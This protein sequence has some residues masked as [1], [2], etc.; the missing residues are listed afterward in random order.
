MLLLFVM[1]C[2]YV[3]LTSGFNQLL[4]LLVLAVEHV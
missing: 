1:I 4:G 2:E 3:V